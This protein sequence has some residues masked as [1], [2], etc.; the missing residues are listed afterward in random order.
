MAGAPLINFVSAEHFLALAKEA[1]ETGN[2]IRFRACRK[3]IAV[4]LDIRES[5]A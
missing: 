1:Y 2:D 5:P 4:A 3:L